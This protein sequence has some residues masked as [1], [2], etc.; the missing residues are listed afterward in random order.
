MTQRELALYETVKI[1]L[2]QLITSDLIDYRQTRATLRAREEAFRTKG[3]C[4]AAA[5][6]GTLCLAVEP[7]RRETRSPH[8]LARPEPVSPEASSLMLDV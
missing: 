2:N 6:M 3:Y 8:P 1:L 5:M 4:D 7:K